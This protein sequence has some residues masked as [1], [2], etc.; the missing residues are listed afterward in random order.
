M[1]N[2]IGVSQ[3]VARVRLQKLRPVRR[4]WGTKVCRYNWHSAGSLFPMLKYKYIFK[5]IHGSNFIEQHSELLWF[6]I[7]KA[8]IAVK[9]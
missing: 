2:V 8:P 7:T 5:K 1:S 3:F 9:K 6:E 4:Q